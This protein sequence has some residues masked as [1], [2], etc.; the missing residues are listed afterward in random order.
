MRF[1]RFAVLL[2][3]TLFVFGCGPSSQKLPFICGGIIGATC[4]PASTCSGFCG[5]PDCAQP[6]QADVACTSDAACPVAY[7][8][9]AASRVCL[10]KTVCQT[11]ADC[12]AT[13]W[14]A[15]RAWGFSNGVCV[16]QDILATTPATPCAWPFTS[17]SGGCGVPCDML[18]ASDGGSDFQCPAGLTCS[19]DS[20]LCR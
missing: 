6:C 11:H 17:R 20:H 18:P 19:A 14:C 16:S 7:G 1:S 5:G 10:P 9:D 4:P 3:A 8:C 13:E 12:A 15:E 2:A